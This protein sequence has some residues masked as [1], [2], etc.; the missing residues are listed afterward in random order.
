MP[1]PSPNGS[2][3]RDSAGKF[4]PGNGGGPGNPHAGRV[5]KLRS[6]LMKA[7]SEKDVRD[8]AKALVTAAKDGDVQAA[9]LLFDR[10]IGK[11]ADDSPAEVE[12]GRNRVL[13][14]LQNRGPSDAAA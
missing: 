4:L 6:A 14:L 13:D 7:V 11:F 1:T 10:V 9:K 5:A 3:G 12:A 8:V 2:N